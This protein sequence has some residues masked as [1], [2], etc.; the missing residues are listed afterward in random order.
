MLMILGTYINIPHNYVNSIY[1][2][3]LI[4]YSSFGIYIFLLLLKKVCTIVVSFKNYLFI[5]N[6]YGE[7]MDYEKVLIVVVGILYRPQRRSV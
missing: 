5:Y 3:F 2:I 4:F 7:K 1:I 6:Q